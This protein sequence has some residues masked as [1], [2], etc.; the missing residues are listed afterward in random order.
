M[1]NTSQERRRYFRVMDVVGLRV[2]VVSEA[3]ADAKT[4]VH[5][6]TV[7]ERLRQV[8]NE[9]HDS[10]DALKRNNEQLA[11]VFGM[12]NHKIDLA[13]SELSTNREDDALLLDDIFQRHQVNISAGGVA[14]PSSRD[15]SEDQSLSVRIKL[16]PSQEVVTALAKV[17]SSE[18]REVPPE[19]MSEVQ[20]LELRERPFWVRLN[21]EDI[22]M[23]EQE[24]LAQ[25]VIRKQA[26]E[27]AFLRKLKDE[28]EDDD[29]ES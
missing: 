9:I 4:A 21:F 20:T 24:L 5:K 15:F 13:V 1:S 28:D 11:L 7:A 26:S 25:H 12:L 14:F 27:L 22:S 3:E 23:V 29:A 17:I 2:S 8:N 6:Q 19:G 10:L 16:F 18:A